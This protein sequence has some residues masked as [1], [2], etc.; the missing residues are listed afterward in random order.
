MK[1]GYFFFT[2]FAQAAP[3]L[4]LFLPAW[5]Y[6]RDSVRFYGS[7]FYLVFLPW[8]LWILAGFAG[9]RIKS[10]SN[11]A[12]EPMLL[13]IGL[14]LLGLA[15]VFLIQKFDQRSLSRTV[16]VLGVILSLALYLLIPTLPA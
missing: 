16:L 5:Y 9:I 13:G 12:V 10:L 7:D 3:L 1:F 4:M 8:L 11:V 6:R 14:A 2:W 15:R